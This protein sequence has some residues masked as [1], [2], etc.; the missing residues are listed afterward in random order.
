MKK[1]KKLSLAL[2]SAALVLTTAC[3]GGGT[4]ESTTT[5]QKPE[6]SKTEAKPTYSFKL[7]HITPPDHMWHLAAEKFKEELAARSDGRMT[8]EIYPSSQLGSEADMVQQITAGSVDFGFITAAY[9]SSR[10]DAFTAWF[11]PYAFKDLESANAARSTDVAKKIL[12]TVEDQG[13]Q[14]LDYLFAGNRVMLTKD[15]EIKGP[16]DMKGLKFRVTPSPPLQDWYKSLGASPESLA[17]PEVYAAVQTGVIDGMDMDLD[18]TITN[19]YHEVTKYG[20]VTNHMVWPAVAL[21]NKASFDKMPDEDKKIIEEAINA[22][23]EYA[24]TTRSGQEEEFKKT[25]ADKGMKIYE[26]DPSVFASQIKQFDEKYGPTNPLI[27]EF[28]STFRK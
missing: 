25:L 8:M 18:A 23:A 11:A 14:G 13:L 26:V 15:R 5:A 16:E 21:M 10:A 2:M 28:I 20:A 1:I 3:G 9:M 17:L 22:A 27:Q 4:Q 19:K 24:V 12:A 7:A 6:E